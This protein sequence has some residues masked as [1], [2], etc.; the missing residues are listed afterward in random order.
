MRRLPIVVKV[1]GNELD[2]PGFVAALAQAIAPLQREKPC[3]V[4]HG[5]GRR[6]D[7]L[8]AR[9]DIQPQYAPGGQRITDEA[10]LEIV[11]MVLSG[12]VNKRIVRALLAAGVDA[13]GLSGVDRGLLQVE[14]CSPELGRVGRVTSVR[15]DVLHDLIERGVV[16]VISPISA[17][18]DGAYNVNADHAAGAIAASVRAEYV[19]FVTNVPGVLAE[20]TAVP[21]LSADEVHRLI[22]QGVIHGGMIPKVNAALDALSSAV[23]AV[24]ITDLA[25]LGNGAGTRIV[26]A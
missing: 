3:I 4:V 8:L 2:K 17:G 14:L 21:R 22:E 25:G 11:E 1:G 10:T 13:E 18:P 16:P 6:V 12:Q 9:L 24:V 20:G 5:G 26:P 15:A 23:Q 19:A 7:D